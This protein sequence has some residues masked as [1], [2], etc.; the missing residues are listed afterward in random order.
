MKILNLEQGSEEWKQARIGRITGTRLG[1]AIG[2]P[3]KQEALLNELIAEALTEQSKE[4][5]INSAMKH[6]TEAEDYAIAEYEQMTGEI[7]EQ[8][9]FCLHDEYDWLANSP[10]RLIK[11]K[12]KYR[13]AVEV[14]APNSETAVKYIRGG[15]I[16]K[17]YEGQ[18]MSYFLVN[19][20]LQELDFV[21]FD[22]RIR[23]ERYRLTVFHMERDEA[24]IAEAWEK[25]IRFYNQ[26]Q[27]AL[28]DLK[29]TF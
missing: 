21:I 2:T 11:S 17:E 22:P 27:Q 7:T 3:A 10:D 24:K 19:E 25:L 1:D 18:V 23:N 13:K 15:K 9:G 14:K 12:G 16:P 26:W 20:D 5:F 8:V 29:L 28:A 4:I 6:G